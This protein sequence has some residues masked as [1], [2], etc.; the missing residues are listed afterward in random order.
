MALEDGLDLCNSESSAEY[1]DYGEELAIAD[2]YTPEMLD[3]K[4]KPVPERVTI[5]EEQAERL[6]N[7][8]RAGGL[9]TVSGVGRQET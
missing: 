9:V 8:G 2:M 7:R 5:T 3:E 1:S 6:R 4:G